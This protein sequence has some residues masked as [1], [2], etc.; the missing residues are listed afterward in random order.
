[1]A[2]DLTHCHQ[3]TEVGKA[4]YLCVYIY[5]IIVFVS[6]K[7]VELSIMNVNI[8]LKIPPNVTPTSSLN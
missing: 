3:W 6:L 5:G 4:G 8:S 2:V 7:E 1:M